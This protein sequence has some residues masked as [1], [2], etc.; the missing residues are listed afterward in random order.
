MNNDTQWSLSFRYVVAIICFAAVVVF[1]I[2]AREAVINLWMRRAEWRDGV[3]LTRT[4]GDFP[5]RMSEYVFGYLLA[6]ELGVARAFHEMR[7]RTW[8]RWTPGSIAG[9]RLLYNSVVGKNEPKPRPVTGEFSI[10]K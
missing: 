5:E 10:A 4:V 3:T 8:K 7:T 2:Y 1:L 9:R 6:Q